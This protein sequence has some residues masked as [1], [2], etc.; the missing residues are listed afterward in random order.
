MKVSVKDI[1]QP[2]SQIKVFELTALEGGFLPA[3]KAGAHIDVHLSNGL[4]RQYSLCNDSKQRDR[5]E[6]GV[7]LDDQSRGGSQYIHQNINIGDELEIS[8]PR[9]LFP[10]TQEQNKA[11]LLAGGIGITPLMSMAETLLAKE[12]DFELYYFCRSSDHVAFKERLSA[13]SFSDKVHFVHKD[14]VESL[15]LVSEILAEPNSGTH[16][17]TCGPNSFMNSIFEIA[18]AKGWQQT[19]LHKESFQAEAI[20]A[21]QSRAFK[22]KIASTGEVLDIPE[23]ESITEVLEEN[24]YY[25]SVSCEQGIC[26]TCVTHILEGEAEH[27]DNFLSD[28]EKNVQKVFTPCCS[29]AKTE[30]LVLDI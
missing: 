4:I 26:G 1:Q 8:E 22:V 9:N 30:M 21:G 28:D 14:N 3:F 27:H 29:R 25:I 6:I 5:Y 11:L 23:D 10:L 12:I 18:L 7:L 17:Y 19:N 13:D 16:L 24:G 20:E 15:A 2:C